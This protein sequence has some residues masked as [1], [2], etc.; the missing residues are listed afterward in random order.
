[1]DRWRERTDQTMNVSNIN[2]ATN[3][4]DKKYCKARKSYPQQQRFVDVI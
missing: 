2:K 3:L 1:M 4:L